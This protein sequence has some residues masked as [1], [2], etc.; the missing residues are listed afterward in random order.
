MARSW[1]I[2]FSTARGSVQ[3]FEVEWVPEHVYNI[4]PSK[5]TRM[6]FWM[7]LFLPLLAPQD[8]ADDLRK[9]IEKLK[10]QNLELQERLGLLEQSAVED[11]QTIQRMRQLVKFL[12]SNGP[13]E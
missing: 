2:Y 13:S 8:S 3:L 6:A 5:E 7:A 9:E 11:A 10:K 12:E 1:P 4:G